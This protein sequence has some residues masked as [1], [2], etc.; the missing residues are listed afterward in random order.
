MGKLIVASCVGEV[1]NMVGGCGVLVDSGS[2]H[3]L[4]EGILWALGSK[5]KAEERVRISARKRVEKK[6]NWTYTTDNILWAYDTIL[7]KARN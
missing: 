6:Y 3:S 1:R 4:A 7:K 2:F 5:N